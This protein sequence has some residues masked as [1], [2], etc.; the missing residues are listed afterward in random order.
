MLSLW[1]ASFLALLNADMEYVET[2]IQNI[3]TLFVKD[4]SEKENRDKRF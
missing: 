3:S 2:R 1:Q 4:L